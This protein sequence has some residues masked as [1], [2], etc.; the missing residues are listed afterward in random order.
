MKDYIISAGTTADL[1]YEHFKRRNIS[2]IDFYFNLD[3]V[4]YID[5]LGRTMSFSDFYKKMAEGAMSRTSQPNTEQFIAY[6]TPFLEAGKDVIHLSLSSA[7]SGE[8]NSARLAKE[9]LEEK[10]P[11]RKIF[12]I[13]SKAA[14]GGFGLLVDKLADLRDEGMDITKLAAWTE[15]NKLRLNHWFYT[16]DLKYFVRGG[17]LTKLSGFMG[18][19]LNINPLLHVNELGELIPKYKVVGQRRVQI[20]TLDLV[21]ELADGGLEYA[22]KVYINHAEMLSDALSLE[23]TIKNRFKNVTEIVI[24]YIGTTIGAHTGPGTVAIFFWGKARDEN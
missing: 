20:K 1:S 12:I 4:E 16:T 2:Y 19:L 22:D 13:D 6:L 9:E 14:S 10:Y 23:R 5:D 11:D 21:R 7:L 17:R 8:F 3:G 15:Q 24:N 18:N